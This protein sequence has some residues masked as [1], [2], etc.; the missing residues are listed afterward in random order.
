[1]RGRDRGAAGRVGCAIRV[2][3]D[4]LG[5]SGIVAPPDSPLGGGGPGYFRL[6]G[7]LEENGGVF[8]AEVRERLLWL[9]GGSAPTPARVPPLT[10]GGKYT[11]FRAVQTELVD[12]EVSVEVLADGNAS[13]VP[14]RSSAATSFVEVAPSVP[15]YSYR[16]KN[17]EIE[18][19]TGKVTWRGVVTLQT[20]Y[21]SGVKRTD[22]S[23]YGRGTTEADVR[24]RDITLGFHEDCHLRDYLDYMYRNPLP[25]PP[26][27]EI[28]MAAAEYE[29]EKKQ[30]LAAAAAYWRA[31]EAYSESNTDEVGFTRTRHL[32]NN[33]CFVHALPGP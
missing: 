3:R 17:R 25:P 7:L 11:P 14:A 23:C 31:M 9:A 19:F 27:I 4:W 6:I 28:G 13:S 32:A 8:D 18:S 26:K 21:K 15:G 20:R 16:G 22:L 33:Q 5:W 29:A 24:A 30:F 2:P 12:I 1:M 10:R